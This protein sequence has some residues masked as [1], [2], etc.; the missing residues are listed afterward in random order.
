LEVRTKLYSVLALLAGATPGLAADIASSPMPTPVKAPVAV[1][2]FSWTGIYVG[3]EVGGGQSHLSGMDPTMPAAGWTSV[4]TN[5]VIA[6]GLL[7]FNYQIGNVVLGAEGSYAWSG[8]NMTAGGPFAGGPGLTISDKND[9]IA[10]ATGRL[11]YAFDR[12][13]VYGKGGAAWTR[14]KLS[15]NDGLGGTASGNFNRTGWTAGAGIEYAF[16][17]N[18]SVKLEYDF[19]RFGGINEQPATTGNL[20]VTP[21]IIKLDMQKLMVGLNYRF[22]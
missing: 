22:F 14:D 13:L 6:G 5:G 19:L 9:Y 15:A 11:G 20:G 16:W 17:Q 12:L 1:A 4:N 2:I 7:G 18:L 3:G 10:T 21:A 8:I